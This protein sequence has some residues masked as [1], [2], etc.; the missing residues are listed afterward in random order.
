[1]PY[2]IQFISFLSWKYLLKDGRESSDAILNI[3]FLAHYSLQGCDIKNRRPSICKHNHYLSE[4]KKNAQHNYDLTPRKCKTF[5]HYSIR[6]KFPGR[7]A[8]F[9]YVIF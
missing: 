4:Y 1:M 5:F 3:P 9:M 7:E 2:F 6:F 8:I